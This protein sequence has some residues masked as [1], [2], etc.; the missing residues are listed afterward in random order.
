[1][2]RVPLECESR[3]TSRCKKTK[4]KKLERGRWPKAHQMHVRR[5]G[6][7]KVGTYSK[8]RSSAESLATHE[9]WRAPWL[10]KRYQRRISKGQ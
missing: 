3:L 6:Y 1:M 9:P 7:E 5:E 4:M 8:E 2:A 10:R